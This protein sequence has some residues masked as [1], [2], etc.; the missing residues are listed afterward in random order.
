MHRTDEIEHIY[1]ESSLRDGIIA[2]NL[3][4][5]THGV[6]LDYTDR[7]QEILDH[8]RKGGMLDDKR[9]LLL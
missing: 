8:Y 7:P 3:E 2:R 1:I 4:S 5:R 9:V 6:T